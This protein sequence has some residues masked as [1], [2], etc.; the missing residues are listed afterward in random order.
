M[1]SALRVRRWHGWRESIVHECGY[2]KVVHCHCLFACARQNRKVWYYSE[3]YE[4]LRRYLQMHVQVHRLCALALMRVIHD[5]W[6]SDGERRA[7]GTAGER[8]GQ[9]SFENV[10]SSEPEGAGQRS[11]QVMAVVAVTNLKLYHCGADGGQAPVI[12]SAATP[13]GTQAT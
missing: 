4:R 12:T 3:Y 10:C 6:A 13:C 5:V 9:S 1:L 2:L 8:H 7:V 11:D